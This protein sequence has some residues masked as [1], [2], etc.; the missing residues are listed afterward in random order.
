[1]NVK[2]DKSICT[3]CTLCIQT[4]SEIFI[5]DSDDRAKAK[6]NPKSEDENKCC[7]QAA[8]ECPVEAIIIT[9]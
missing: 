5:M 4:C 6:R 9:D 2:V 7:Q 1:M 8:S 3:G